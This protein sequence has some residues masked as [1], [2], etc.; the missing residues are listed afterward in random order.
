MNLKF[1]TVIVM[2][3]I[4]ASM[5]V[6]SVF[7]Q[8]A[9]GNANTGGPSKKPKCAF[10]NDN[11]L[12][13]GPHTSKKKGKAKSVCEEKL[14]DQ[15]EA[16][17]TKCIDFCTNLSSCDFLFG[18]GP[19]TCNEKPEKKKVGGGGPGIIAICK[20]LLGTTTCKGKIYSTPRGKPHEWV[21]TGKYTAS[22]SSN[23]EC[24]CLDP[25]SS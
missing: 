17:R 18:H 2:I 8:S 20:W 12:Y 10:A 6:A 13:E 3:C 22:G 14:G 9:G 7:G 15:I 19:S 11:T 21:N 1:M 4:V 5:G 25:P 16:E 23:T 24:I